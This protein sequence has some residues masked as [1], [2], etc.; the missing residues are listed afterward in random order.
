MPR[1]G[2]SL[3]EHSGPIGYLISMENSR[4]LCYVTDC[5]GPFSGVSWL[6]VPDHVE[7]GREL[8]PPL[9][10]SILSFMGFGFTQPYQFFCLVAWSTCPTK[11]Y[12]LREKMRFL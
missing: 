2:S 3:A 8:A 6:C 5:H 12:L 7:F 9:L 4:F 1:T 10:F 11:G